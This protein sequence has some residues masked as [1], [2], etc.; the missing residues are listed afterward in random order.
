MNKNAYNDNDGGRN[1]GFDN[2]ELKGSSYWKTSFNE[3]CVAMK[4]GGQL[5][6]FSF[7]Y[8]ASSLYDL[9]ADG[10]YRQTRIGRSQWKQLIHG[11]S[12]QRN[13]NKEG[14][15]VNPRNHAKA[16]FGIL[17]NQENNCDSTDSFIGLGA[18]YQRTYCLGRSAHNAAGNV[19]S[20]SPDNGDKN[21][22]VMGYILVR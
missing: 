21:I 16:R 11:S 13:C 20:C 5:R 9:I 22:K 7:S 19:A 8:P 3:I 4:Y 1:G 2:R 12:L 15:N 6:A 18:N 17:G 10:K 14:F